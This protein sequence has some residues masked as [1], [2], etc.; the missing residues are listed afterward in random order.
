MALLVILISIGIE[1]FLEGVENLRNYS[2][3]LKLAPRIQKPLKPHIKDPTALVVLTFLLPLLLV[4]I[5]Y[6]YLSHVHILLGYL[7]NI[8]VLVYCM[9]PKS[10]LDKIQKFL[11]AHERGDQIEAKELSQVILNGYPVENESD[12]IKMINKTALIATNNQLLGVFFWFALLGPIG[13]LLYRFSDVLLRHK[14]KDSA[15]SEEYMQT[16]QLLF[17]IL[18]W[19][20]AHLTSLIYALTGSF[21]DAMHQWKIHRNYD[22]FTPEAANNMLVDTGFGAILIEADTKIFDGQTV[23]DVLGLCRRCIFV[24]V[25]LLAI[26]TIALA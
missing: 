10:L 16:L 23:H 2:W 8:L 15:L 1:K 11:E 24:W 4:A 13:A 20:P 12:M 22:K 19:I 5:A 7:F 18:N 25:V 17:T 9:G 26:V 14:A 21:V 6:Q 3:F